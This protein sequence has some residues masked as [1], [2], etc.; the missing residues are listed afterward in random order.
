MAE[1]SSA[2]ADLEIAAATHASLFRELQQRQASADKVDLPCCQQC[3]DEG[4]L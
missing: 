3:S 4:A 1:L 2:A